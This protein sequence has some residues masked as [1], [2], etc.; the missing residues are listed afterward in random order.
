MLQKSLTKLAGTIRKPEIPQEHALPEENG[1]AWMPSVVSLENLAQNPIQL[2]L[3]EEQT[4]PMVFTSPHS[5]R[6][7]PQEF[8]NDSR[9]PLPQLRRS[10]DCFMDL[11]MSQVSGFGAPFLAANFPRA[12]VDVNREAYEW[13]PDMFDAPLPEGINTSSIRVKGGLGTIARV[14]A[15]GEDIYQRKLSIHEGEER[16]QQFYH[17]YHAALQSLIK[18]T[19]LRFGF[20]LLIDCHSMPTPLENPSHRSGYAPPAVSQQPEAVIGDCYGLSCARTVTSMAEQALKQQMSKV[21][22][23]KPYAGGYTTRHYGQPKTGV[24]ALQIE[25]ARAL[26]MNE[27]TLE[28]LSRMENLKAIPRALIEAL[29][30]IPADSLRA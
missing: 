20:C 21:V 10:E 15:N 27:T 24:H 1:H 28:P 23:N 12:F 14:V 16:I 22:R 29:A 19:Q 17:P 5:G 6:C 4:L 2:N 18:E 8:V 11:I 26:Y 25:M 7:Y 13:D 3:P 9:L 30:Q